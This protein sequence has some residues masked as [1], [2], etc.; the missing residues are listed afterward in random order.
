MV[1]TVPKLFGGTEIT[2]AIGH[3]I[4]NIILDPG[5]SLVLDDQPVYFCPK[6]GPPDPDRR[7][8]VAEGSQYFVPERGTSLL[9]LAANITG[10]LIGLIAYQVL[11]PFL[12]SHVGS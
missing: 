11:N 3:V 6:N 5:V 2:D 4:I 9:D 7:G 1:S 8:F 10:V 12:R